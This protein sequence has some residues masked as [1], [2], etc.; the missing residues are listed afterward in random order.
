VST[1]E[2]RSV[3][4]SE[5]VS[6]DR[7]FDALQQDQR[8][9]QTALVVAVVVLS[10]VLVR[11]MGL[12]GQGLLVLVLDLIC[13]AAVVVR[14]LPVRVQDRFARPLPYVL[15]I[16]CAAALVVV[17]RD[18]YAVTFAFLLCGQMGYRLVPRRS[19]P[20][21]AFACVLL[22]L[23]TELGIHL[24][25]GRGSWISGVL[26]GFPVLLGYSNR[27]RRLALVSAQEAADERARAEL[28]AE[29]ARIGRDIHDVLAHSLA[30]VKLQLEAVDAL[31]E[32]G[33]QGRA[34]KILH[35]AQSQVAIGL[36]EA[37][38]TVRALREDTLELVPTLCAL[39]ASSAPEGTELRCEGERFEV[40]TP[41]ATT[42]VRVVQE[43]LT[44]AARYA[45][46][47]RVEVGL[48]FAPH[49]VQV[50][51][52]SG[53]AVGEPMREGGSGMGLVG[54]RERLAIV[55]GSLRA[56]PVTDGEFTGGWQV[57]AVIPV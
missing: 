23:T 51:V 16:L 8:I 38:R 34:T 49:Q 20:I 12:S 45:P 57:R 40:S 31:M 32:A 53:P 14:A 47:A 3:A 11:P 33:Q 13:C 30:A 56:G 24:G 43:S 27:Q 6:P 7:T 54:M 36:T 1:R 2:V 42:L 19:M 50:R 22:L 4:A 41:V 48:G 37:T 25:T 21:A 44:N 35:D 18:G 29:R 10:F 52:L 9:T 5:D 46:G 39:V 26:C 15:A 28:M 55:S 17:D